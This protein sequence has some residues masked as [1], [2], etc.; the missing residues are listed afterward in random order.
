MVLKCRGF[1]FDLDGTL[2]DSLPAVERAWIQFADKMGIERDE[3]LNYVHGTP[4]ILSLRHFMPDASEEEIAG[5]FKWIEKI[6]TEDTEGITALPGAIALI[7]KLNALDIPW[8]IVTS[9]T[10]PLASARHKVAELPEPAHWVTAESVTNGK[11]NPEP[12]L[13]GAKKLGLLPEEC[14]VF[15]DAAAGINAGLDAGCQVV[16]VHDSPDI[17]RRD[18]IHLTVNNLEDIE[19]V[20]SGSYVSIYTD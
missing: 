7:D 19:I 18:E 16:V 14:V 6:E 3:V 1:L 5:T 12:Y 9:G 20:K 17:P 15:E 2:V 11:P 13:L 8:A 4:A 10:V